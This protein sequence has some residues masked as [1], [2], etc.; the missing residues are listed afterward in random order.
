MNDVVSSISNFLWGL[1]MIVILIGT[2]IYFTLRLR[3]PQRHILK[4]IKLSFTREEGA[5]GD[6]SHFTTLTMSLAA[7]IGTGNIVGVATA[8]ILGGPGAVFWCWMAGVLGISTKYA[9]GIL[10]IKYRQQTKKGKM[11]GGPMYALERGLGKKWLAILFSAFCALASFGIGNMVQSNAISNVLFDLYDVPLWLSG[12]VVATAAALVLLGGVKSIGRVCNALTPVMVLVYLFG[13]TYLMVIN[14]DFLWPALKLIFT[15]AFSAEAVGGGLVGGGAILAMRYGIARGLFSNESGMGSA[16]IIAAAAKTNDPVHQALVSSTSTFWDTVVLC[17][18]TGLTFV[19]SIL[20][21][22][23]ILDQADGGSL[24]H[25]TFGKIGPY[26]D[27][28]LAMCII[29]FA[30]STI[31]GWNYYGERCVEYIGGG[32]WIPRYRVIY[33]VATYIGALLPLV[34][35][36]NLSDI[37]NALMVIPNVIALFGLTKVI[38]HETRSHGLL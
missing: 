24:S 30:F 10:A 17:M 29:A 20:H 8:I 18:I 34:L 28:M 23:E 31:V 37:F 15:S 25:L 35:V 6:V 38:V 36:W 3:F 11:I 14:V 22:P 9:E 26:G 2:H 19:S 21:F 1:P 4:A 13:C 7:T 12:G 33:I 16:P 5:T 27:S 32:K